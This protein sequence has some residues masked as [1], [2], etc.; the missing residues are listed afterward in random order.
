MLLKTHWQTDACTPQT[1]THTHTPSISQTHK[2][3]ASIWRNLKCIQVNNQLHFAREREKS[4]VSKALCKHYSGTGQ[5][6]FAGS[7]VLPGQ[8]TQAF[9]E[10]ESIGSSN[11]DRAYKNQVLLT[12][13]RGE[14]MKCSFSLKAVLLT[15]QSQ[16][17][18]HQHC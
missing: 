8:C 10:K 3:S 18:S 16:H 4:P 2:V 5:L 9:L 13:G 7:V 6:L 15:Y 17:L 14:N 1:H 12:S 11:L